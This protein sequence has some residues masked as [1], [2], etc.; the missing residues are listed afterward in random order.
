MEKTTQQYDS[1]ITEC[2]NLFINKTKDYGSSWRIMRLPSLTEQIYIKAARIRDLQEL[3]TQRVDED[4]VSEFICIINYSIMSLIQLQRGVSNKPDMI[5]DECIKLYDEKVGLTKE[6]MLDKNH[7]YGEVW[8]E[9]RVSSITDLIIQKLF[10]VKQLEDNNGKTLV[11]EGLDANYQDIINYSI[12]S[13][14]LLSE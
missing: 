2:R 14:I 10:R 9:L 1:V 13:I 12:F 5:F 8:R 7:D 11:S 4:E 3:D 6:L